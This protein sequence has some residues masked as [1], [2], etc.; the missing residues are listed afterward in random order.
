MLG[1]SLNRVVP[2][3]HRSFAT[4]TSSQKP[5]APQEPHNVEPVT[6]LLTDLMFIGT[7]LDPKNEVKSGLKSKIGH[8]QGHYF[9][10]VDKLT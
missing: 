3:S 9:G 10:E 5:L 8:K 2:T 6:K 7:N 4:V 1:S